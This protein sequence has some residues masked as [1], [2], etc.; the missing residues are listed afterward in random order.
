MPE[1][2]PGKHSAP[3]RRKIKKIYKIKCK[4]NV[5]IMEAEVI[6]TDGHGNASEMEVMA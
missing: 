1:R 2:K 6:M 4:Q 3:D 5:Y